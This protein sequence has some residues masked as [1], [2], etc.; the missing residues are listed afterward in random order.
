[1]HVGT[2][3]G[4]VSHLDVCRWELRRQCALSKKNLTCSVN[5]AGRGRLAINLIRIEDS[6]QPLTAALALRTWPDLWRPANYHLDAGLHYLLCISIV[7]SGLSSQP[8]SARFQ[9]W[10]FLD[11]DYFLVTVKGLVRL[12]LATKCAFSGLYVN[13]DLLYSTDCLRKYCFTLF[14]KIRLS[15]RRSC[16]ICLLC[17][18]WHLLTRPLFAFSNSLSSLSTINCCALNDSPPPLA[19]LS[20]FNNPFKRNVVSRRNSHLYLVPRALQPRCPSFVPIYRRCIIG[21]CCASYTAA[22][23]CGNHKDVFVGVH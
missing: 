20:F 22:R 13:I 8:L 23:D 18:S 17:Y 2:Y 19:G 4:T 14:A 11:A 3:T 12:V 16:I 10:R 15:A 21:F 1:M 5:G 9:M 6:N 7:R